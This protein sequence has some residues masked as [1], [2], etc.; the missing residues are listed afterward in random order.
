MNIWQVLEIEATQD[1]NAIKQAYAKKV[2]QC[3]PEVD[4]QGF[5]Q[6][7]SAYEAAK[8]YAAGE[9]VE[10]ELDDPVV[11]E[12]SQAE[13]DTSQTDDDVEQMVFYL[14]DVLFKN[15]NDA[16]DLLKSFQKNGQLDNLEFSDQFQRL[17]ARRLLAV[18]ES[19]YGFVNYAIYFFDWHEHPALAQNSWF[20][21]SLKSLINQARSYRLLQKQKR[22]VKTLVGFIATLIIIYIA[23]AVTSYVKKINALTV[24]DNG[25]NTGLIMINSTTI[26]VTMASTSQGEKLNGVNRYVV[27]VPKAITQSKDESWYFIMRDTK[28]H[29]VAN[30]LNRYMLF[31]TDKLQYNPDGS[32]DLYIQHDSPG[33]DKEANWLPAPLENFMLMG[34]FIWKKDATITDAWKPPVV[35]KLS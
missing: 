23:V 16:I 25:T 30:L 11:V 8:K 13:V 4:P 26:L 27:H 18:A 15:E 17:L 6:V 22:I 20:G 12:A 9:A 29:Y 10:L 35:E 34:E 28:Y 5:Q 19:Y 32:V 1:L 33:K 14:M 3:K 21:T 31:S 24:Y 7:R 2:K